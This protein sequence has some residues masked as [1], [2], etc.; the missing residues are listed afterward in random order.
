MKFYITETERRSCKP[1]IIQHYFLK[2]GK[3]A[4]LLEMAVEVESDDIVVTHSEILKVSRSEL[5]DNF[6]TFTVRIPE[7][8]EDH[9]KNYVVEFTT[10][11]RH[12]K[13]VKQCVITQT[14]DADLFEL[15]SSELC[16]NNILN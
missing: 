16:G 5:K 14:L 9:Y 15:C 8:N 1:V 13:I 12:Q 3:G 10:S 6:V 2:V 7:N 4:Q 11:R